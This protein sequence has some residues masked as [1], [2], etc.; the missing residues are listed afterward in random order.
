MHGRTNAFLLVTLI[1]V[2][3]AAEEGSP[4]WP[5]FRGPEHTGVA[6]GADPPIEWGEDKNVRW[7][8]ELEGT[9]H[10]SPVVWGNRIFVMSAVK[11][12]KE[13]EAEPENE[14][15][16]NRAA[17][18]ILL[19]SQQSGASKGQAQQQQQQRR[20]RPPRVKP[21]H[22]HQFM[23]SAYDLASGKRVWNTVVRE[24]VPHESLHSTAS[25]VSASPV[26]DGEHVWA[27]FGSRGLY[28]LDMQGDVVW[29]KQFG[30]QTT[31][32]EFGEGASPAVHG[33]LI[34]INWDH[35]GDSFIVALDKKT[36]EQ[37]WRVARDE[38]TSWST[39]LVVRDGK[40]DVVVVSAWSRV[41][42]YDLASGEELWSVSG[43]G[44]NVV[45]TP[46]ADNKMIWV[47]SGWRDAHGMAIRYPGARGD[48]TGSDRVW[49]E[50]EIGLSYVPS[51]VL[52]G[53][54]VFFFQRF[55]GILSCYELASG[56]A[57]Y[58]RQRI[59]GYEDIYASLVAAGD[60]AYSVSRDGSGL[61]FSTTGEFEVLA[62]NELDDV[63]NATPAIVGDT[64]I[65]RG[66]RYL[67]N[68]SAE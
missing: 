32:N 26:T 35:E 62:R 28:C 14:T 45:P 57:C 19:A 61:V 24:E 27:F 13:I 12:D 10:A 38:R 40:K 20:S 52:A 4:T 48:L 43:L 47:M 67:Y 36:G 18:P 33:G 9:G 6:P 30:I 55:A 66:D 16:R 39:P 46:V 31:R 65:L 29:E 7:K 51:A 37:R 34:V 5:S 54:R 3:M 49:W 63:F 2:P 44:P 64:I 1:C 41:V 23:V 68:I 56:E 59:D 42:G 11:T 58:D 25:Q 50:A 17:L 60:R 15:S 53:G 22:V 21:T 8:V